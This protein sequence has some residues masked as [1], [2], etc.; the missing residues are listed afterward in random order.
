MGRTAKK[1]MLIFLCLSAL[2]IVGCTK[3]VADGTDLSGGSTPVSFDF[4]D[5]NGLILQSSEGA[6]SLSVDGPSAASLDKSNFKK[7]RTSGS[8]EDVVTAG[9]ASISNFYVAP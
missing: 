5:S 3:R 6:S 9:S 8:I 2:A 1:M 4:S 7:L